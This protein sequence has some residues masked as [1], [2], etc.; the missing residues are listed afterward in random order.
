MVEAVS[1]GEVAEG[2][3]PHL[4]AAPPDSSISTAS[5][6]ELSTEELEG[7]TLFEGVVAVA[8]P[9][10]P[11]PTPSTLEY[12]DAKPLRPNVVRL[13]LVKQPY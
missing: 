4:T 12:V 7:G 10:T 2:D 5:F 3:L 6:A 9:M 8:Y 11:N 13:R 1:Q